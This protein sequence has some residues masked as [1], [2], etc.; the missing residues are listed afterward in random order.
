MR[1]LVLLALGVVL[2]WFLD[3]G[4]RRLSQSLGQGLG[5]GLREGMGVAET[6]SPETPAGRVVEML[7]PCARCGVYVP[8]TRGVRPGGRSGD[9]PVFCSEACARR[10]DRDSDMGGTAPGDTGDAAPGNIGDAAPGNT[11]QP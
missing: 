7:T 6:G 4:A 3:R 8:V 1:L 2:W 9:G 5:Q 10:A 11:E